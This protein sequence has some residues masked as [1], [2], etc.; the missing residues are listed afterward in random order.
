[1]TTVKENDYFSSGN[2][3]D[4]KLSDIHFPIETLEITRANKWTVEF[5]TCLYVSKPCNVGASWYCWR[6]QIRTAGN[7]KL[8]K[9]I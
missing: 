3:V 7:E 5:F 8:F 4:R 1:V 6:H 9:G 2:E